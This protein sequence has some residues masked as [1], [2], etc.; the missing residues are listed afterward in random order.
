MK[1]LIRYIKGNINR[2]LYFTDGPLPLTAYADADWAGDPIDRR[3]TSGFVV[4]L[5]ATPVSWSAKKQHTVARSSTEVEY[6]A[7]A[8][9]AA[10]LVWIQQLLTY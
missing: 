8:Q 5:G 4:F 3:S 7:M 6:R 10:D 1:R 2:G 9:T